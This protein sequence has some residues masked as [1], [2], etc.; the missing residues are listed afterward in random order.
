MPDD[1]L[2][3]LKLARGVHVLI[4][5]LVITG[6]LGSIPQGGCHLHK[7]GIH[8]RL[9]ILNHRLRGLMQNKLDLVTGCP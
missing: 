3:G 7:T 9:N 1:P 2:T 6:L 8:Q 5:L 4:R